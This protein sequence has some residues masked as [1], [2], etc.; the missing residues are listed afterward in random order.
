MDVDVVLCNERSNHNMCEA[1]P[2]AILTFLKQTS[3][4]KQCQTRLEV[5]AAQSPELFR[6]ALDKF[7]LAN[8]SVSLVLAQTFPKCSLS[9]VC[10][11]KMSMLCPVYVHFLT[12]LH[13]C[14]CTHVKNRNGIF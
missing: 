5:A 14:H 2:L 10:T 6:Q 3:A 13:T 8:T 12:D 4:F 1:M 11:T 7:K 9:P